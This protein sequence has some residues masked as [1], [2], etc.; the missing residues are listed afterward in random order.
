MIRGL[1]KHHEQDPSLLIRDTR[2]L[3][4]KTHEFLQQPAQSALV[5]VILAVCAFVFH[6]IA[7]VI[8]LFGACL[9]IYCI[10]VSR[11]ARLPY[12]MPM[13]SGALDYN[14]F[15]PTS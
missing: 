10:T 2:T 13:C 3:G 12:R 9:S 11:R 1:E 14:D 6:S 7:D 4:Q 15:F 8:L 5:F